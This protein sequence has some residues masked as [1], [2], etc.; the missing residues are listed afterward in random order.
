MLIRI[1]YVVWRDI[2]I[3][4]LQAGVISQAANA[5]KVERHNSIADA[6]SK[7]GVVDPRKNDRDLKDK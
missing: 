5:E 2:D 3:V 6:I 1:A 4:D 7:S